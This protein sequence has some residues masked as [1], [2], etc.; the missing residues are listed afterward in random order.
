MNV[1]FKDG[2]VLLVDGKVAT[3]S[4]CCCGGGACCIDG[5][6]SILSSDDCSSGGGIY[7]GDGSVCEG[8]NCLFA[9][10]S[11]D[12]V[13]TDVAGPDS[14]TLIGENYVF[15]PGQKCA[16]NP[17]PAGPCCIPATDTCT[18]FELVL[19]PS[20]GEQC[21]LGVTVIEAYCD[22]LPGGRWLGPDAICSDCDI[23]GFVCCPSDVSCCIDN[24]EEGYY[25]GFPECNVLGIFDDPF[26]QNN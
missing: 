12:G 16:D 7:L 8:E 20:L 15:F 24:P 26:F 1:Y 18:P 9:C 13:C 11:I 3:S 22:L 4:D 17:C 21:F 6:C 2:K 23:T 14:C 5:V 25:C 10:C 19:C